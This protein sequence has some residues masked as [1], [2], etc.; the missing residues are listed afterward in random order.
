MHIPAK[1]HVLLFVTALAFAH[2]PD[3]ALAS[4]T[5]TADLALPDGCV[6]RD[7]T[8]AAQN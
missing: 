3:H 6:L 2:P 1:K 8:S 5:T 7:R 4:G